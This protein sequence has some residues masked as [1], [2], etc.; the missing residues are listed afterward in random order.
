MTRTKADWPSS[1]R[2]FSSGPAAGRIK[3]GTLSTTSGR[4]YHDLFTSLLP[5]H[6]A[7]GIGG[8][9]HLIAATA[10]FGIITR[11]SSDQKE[12]ICGILVPTSYLVYYPLGRAGKSTP[13]ARAIRLYPPIFTF[14]IYYSIP[15]PLG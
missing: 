2:F 1:T 15:S 7:A 3:V 13:R 12:L 10:L 6:E 14:N 11:S 8:R 9:D 4:R 5:A